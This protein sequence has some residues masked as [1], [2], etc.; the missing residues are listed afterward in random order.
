MG[1]TRILHFRATENEYNFIMQKMK[2]CNIQ[3]LSAY[4]LKMAVDGNVIN[5]DMP[6]LKEISR[7]LRYNGNNINQIAKRLNEGKNIYASDIVDIKNKQDK[8]TEMVREI[9]LKLAKL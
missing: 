1:K 6:E 7:L 8:I 5:L 3:S 9:Y 4:L 2:Q